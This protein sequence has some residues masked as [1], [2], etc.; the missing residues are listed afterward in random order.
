MAITPRD[1][2]NIMDEALRAGLAQVRAQHGRRWPYIDRDPETPGWRA[3]RS[4]GPAR[5]HHITAPTLA[6][7]VGEL[8]AEAEVAGP[9]SDTSDT[10][11]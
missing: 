3:S 2:A 7:L 8:E 1:A 10:G 9:P 4:T 6:E 5:W 11:Q